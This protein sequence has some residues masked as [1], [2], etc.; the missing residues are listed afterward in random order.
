MNARASRD[1]SG[2]S[3]TYQNA[4]PN[5]NEPMPATHG[6]APAHASDPLIG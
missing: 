5:A 4:M 3:T 2:R 6:D 1:M